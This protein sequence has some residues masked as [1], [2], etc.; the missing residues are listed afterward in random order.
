[1][2]KQIFTVHRNLYA[3]IDIEVVAE[4]E[5]EAIASARSRF[6]NIRWREYEFTEN[7]VSVIDSKELPSNDDIP[8][9]IKQAI[10][11][12]RQQTDHDGDS[13]SFSEVT[14]RANLEIYDKYINICE[15]YEEEIHID[16]AYVY[17]TEEGSEEIMVQ[18]TYEDI[19]LFDLN[20]FNID[21]FTYPEMRAILQ[22]ILK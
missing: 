17:V 20:D 14:V 12:I 18:A 6:D 9:L 1:M 11:A 16:S 5:E 4:T 19:R 21:E 7:E 8:V 2:S 3:T 13:V 15:T 22:A 10:D